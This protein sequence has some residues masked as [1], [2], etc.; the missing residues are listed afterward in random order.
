MTVDHAQPQVIQPHLSDSLIPLYAVGTSEQSAFRA[1]SIKSHLHQW[2]TLTSDKFIWQSV[3]G[4]TIDFDIL[5]VQ[6]YKPRPI[7]FRPE[8]YDILDKQIKLL[9]HQGVIEPTHHSSPEF[10]SNVFG[11]SKKDGSCRLILNL[12]KFNPFVT[13]H[14]LK[15]DTIETVIS[16]VRH[17]CYMASLDLSNAYFS[18]P[19]NVSDRCYL[20]FEWNDQLFQ[21]TAVPN[22]LS[23][24]P[25]IFTKLLKPVYAVLR[26]M[27]HVISGYIDDS[28][29]MGLSFD[30]CLSNIQDANNLMESLGFHM[31]YAKSVM[32]PTQ[33]LEHLGF[34]LDSRRM[35]VTLTESK[36]DNVICKCKA[37]LL[38]T[39]VKIRK[40]AELIGILVSSFTA[41]QFGP[42]HYRAID[43][44][45]VRALSTHHGDFDQTM[46]LSEA[47]I[48]EIQWWID[49]VKFEVRDIDHYHF[50]YCL[51]TDAS[52]KGWGAVFTD[53]TCETDMVSTGGRGT[54]EETCHHINVLELKA[55]FMGLKSFCS[56]LNGVHIK[57]ELDNMTAIA[58]LQNL[59]G[60]RSKQCNELAFEIWSWC[61]ERDIWLTAVHLPGRLNTLADEKSRVFDD[62][63]E[64]M[65]NVEIFREV[66]NHFV[67]PD[68]DLFASRLNFQIKR[69]VAWMPD[70]DAWCI[71]AFALNW[72]K[73]RF[74]AFPPFSIL[75]HVLRKIELDKAT[76]ILIV[77]EWPTQ[78]WFALLK[79]MLLR[80][81][82][83]LTWRDNLVTLPFTENVH[84]LGRKLR[85]MACYLSGGR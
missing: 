49:N 40:V 26:E 74:Y 75:N 32:V 11:R 13:Y 3:S 53:L 56:L 20:R 72:S 47:A 61:K 63:T 55:G 42:L 48:V 5:P 62:K 45:K 24:G 84:P 82:L 58:Y 35:T 39:T 80:P 54:T 51:T 15:M 76:G 57:M 71:D 34:I 1:G 28:F 16:L 69:Y 7:L 85:L 25:R 8:E 81:P 9:L 17:N 77:P 68:I 14:H 50:S 10:I 2:Q 37:I 18:V 52:G 23:S 67:E 43:Y 70:P 6:M 29:L 46:C 38:P 73:L 27:G 22:G 33:R 12:V 65:L 31:N 59:G 64:W 60:S 19:I 4:V 36:V 41:V 83:R 79:R 30:T 66:V 44:D 78:T 21:F